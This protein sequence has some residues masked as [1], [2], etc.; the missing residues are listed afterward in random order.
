MFYI[1]V[2]AVGEDGIA[3]VKMKILTMGKPL[4]LCIVV[5]EK[6]LPEKLDREFKLLRNEDELGLQ[7]TPRSRSTRRPGEEPNVLI[8]SFRECSFRNLCPKSR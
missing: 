8:A 7:I 4:W 5:R 2:G 3:K 1:V 6:L